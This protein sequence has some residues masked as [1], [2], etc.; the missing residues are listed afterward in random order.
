MTGRWTGDSKHQRPTG[1]KWILGKGGLGKIGRLNHSCVRTWSCISLSRRLNRSRS[2]PSPVKK[3]SS[4]LKLPFFV[5]QPISSLSLSLSFSFFFS[6]SSYIN[7]KYTL[8]RVSF[9]VTFYN[10]LSILIFQLLEKIFSCYINEFCT[11][12]Q[13][14]YY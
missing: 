6:S 11:N 10:S 5:G 4:S 12:S 8:L 7:E 9:W 14:A 13:H 3:L 1:K 2:H